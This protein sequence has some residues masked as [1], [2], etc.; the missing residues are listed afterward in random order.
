MRVQYHGLQFDLPPEWTDITDDLPEGS[1]PTLARPS[2]LGVIQ[3]SITSYRSGTDPEVTGEDLRQ[4]ITDF[5]S[6]RSL[7]AGQLEVT[8]RRIMTVGCVTTA[9]DELVAVWY[10][11]N[12]RDIVVLTY[13]ALSSRDLDTAE[14]L[15]QARQ[16]VATI[17]F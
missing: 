2:G 6:R 5:C 1:P 7:N 11:S 16:L 12:G 4:L 9:T 15:S 13:T 17:D 8:I 3:F 10:L 14:E